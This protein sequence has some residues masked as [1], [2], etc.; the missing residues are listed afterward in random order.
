MSGIG[1]DD[2]MRQR[3]GSRGD[4]TYLEAGVSKGERHHIGDVL[5]VLDQRT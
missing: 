2:E 3:L 5:L 4:N 1:L